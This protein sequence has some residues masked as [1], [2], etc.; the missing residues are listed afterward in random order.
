M[1]HSSTLVY[2]CRGFHRAI[3]MT[4][5]PSSHPVCLRCPANHGA[6]RL[7]I[8]TPP[9]PYI[10]RSFKP[11]GVLGILGLGLFLLLPPRADMPGNLVAR[12]APAAVQLSG[13]AQ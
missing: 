9:S 11:F 10:C 2:V 5:R 12:Q 13:G 3:A 4:F 8:A 6:S 7:S 1:S